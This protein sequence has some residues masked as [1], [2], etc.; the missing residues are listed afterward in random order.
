M[1]FSIQDCESTIQNRTYLQFTNNLSDIYIHDA[2]ILRRRLIANISRLLLVNGHNQPTAP[3]LSVVSVSRISN[4]V[5][6]D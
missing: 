1:P 2:Y 5:Y 3:N 4:I 6:E